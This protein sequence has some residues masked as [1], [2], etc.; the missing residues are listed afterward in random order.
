M[1]TTGLF[2]V[3]KFEIPIRGLNQE[4]PIVIF[5]DVHRDSPNHA[6][7]A[8]QYFLEHARS[9]K[10]ARFL[11]MGDYAD[12][13]STSERHAIKTGGFHESTLEKWENDANDW[14]RRLAKEMSFMKGRLIGLLGGN[15]YYSFED[16]TNTDMRLA[17]ELGC[18]FLGV[19]A[20][21][22]L[23]FSIVN[24]RITYDVLA[25]H[26]TGAGRMV[27]GSLNRVAQM[28]EWA[29]A[30][31]VCMGHDHKRGVVPGIPRLYLQ[32]SQRDGKLRVKHRETKIARTG[33]FL[34]AYEDGEA[35]YNVDAARGP[36]SL[37][38][39]EVWV[40][41]RKTQSDGKIQRWLET[42]GVA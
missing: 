5:G 13:V 24:I 16:G 12:G 35:N 11:G 9:L 21:I 14:V 3:H 40:R 8:W 37:G 10:N 22:R 32:S 15:H 33:S 20:F 26:G 25:H 27:G 2:T 19:S 7:G 41:M 29:E 34:A 38:H 23:V 42:R 1:K 4:T 17:R 36:C 30:D 6:H 39:V 31:L 18:K 28:L